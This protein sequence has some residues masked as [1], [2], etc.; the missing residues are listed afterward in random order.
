M[1]IIHVRP[2]ADTVKNRAK[3]VRETEYCARCGDITGD[4]YIIDAEAVCYECFGKKN[5]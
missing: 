5:K 4:Y 2:I 3:K 1:N